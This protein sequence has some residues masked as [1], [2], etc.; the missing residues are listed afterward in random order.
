MSDSDLSDIADAL[1]SE[2]R[3]EEQLRQTVAATFKAEDFDNLTVK[4]VRAAAAKTLSLD[5]DFLKEGTWKDRSKKIITDE[6]VGRQ[7]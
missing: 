6:V 1:P 7:H 3:I 5:I 4:K 2:S